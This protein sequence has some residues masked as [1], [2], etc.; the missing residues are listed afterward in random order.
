MSVYEERG[1]NIGINSIHFFKFVEDYWR[2]ST[3]Y[4]MQLLKE[5]SKIYNKYID[6]IEKYI[7]L[8]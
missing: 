4:L 6:D 3:V 2:V 8:M 7:M 5:H 1:L